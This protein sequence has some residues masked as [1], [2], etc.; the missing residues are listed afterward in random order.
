M[1]CRGRR[2]WTSQ[3]RSSPST[4]S[5]SDLITGRT[6]LAGSRRTGKGSIFLRLIEKSLSQCIWRSLVVFD[7][8]SAT[9]R[10][11]HTC[12]TVYL[13]FRSPVHLHALEYH[14]LRCVERS[15]I[16]QSNRKQR[17][18]HW[19]ALHHSFTGRASTAKIHESLMEHLSRLVLA[20]W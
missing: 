14:V 10:S 7:L 2:R 12:P 18:S 3:W 15:Q 13:L 20:W 6:C 16:R 4:I 19:S 17:P 11:I 1:V 9:L 5:R 8:L